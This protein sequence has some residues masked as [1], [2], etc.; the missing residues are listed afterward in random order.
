MKSIKLTIIIC[1]LSYN[2]YAQTGINT[3][4]PNATAV[5]DLNSTTK[6]FKGPDIALKGRLDVETIFSPERGLIVFNTANAGTNA[7][8]VYANRYYFWNGTEWV[9]MPGFHAIEELI[10]PRVFYAKSAITQ[11]FNFTNTSQLLV[12]SFETVDLNTVAMISPAANNTFRVNKTGLYELSANVNYNPNGSSNNR[13]LQNLIIQKS[14]S[15]S[16][17]W[18]PIA[19]ARG[20]WGMGT[21]SDFKTIIVPVTAVQLTEGE[22]IRVITA[23]PYPNDTSAQGTGRVSTTTNTPIA[24]SLKIRLIDFSL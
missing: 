1:A 20:N 17:S 2:I 4:L 14:T 21:A 9:S 12:L 15:A 19:G 11:S 8:Q 10:V 22:Y 3:N 23:C 16:G 13:A 6:G 18:T 24:K 7:D 5:L